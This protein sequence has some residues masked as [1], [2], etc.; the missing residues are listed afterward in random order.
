M[1]LSRHDSV[2]PSGWRKDS[3]PLANNFGSQA[4]KIQRRGAEIRRD[5]Q[6]VLLLRVSPRSSA[7]L[8]VRI[9]AARAKS[10]GPM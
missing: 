8:S 4:E 1:I 5:S 2:G 7:L 6:R 9:C 10:L 3:S